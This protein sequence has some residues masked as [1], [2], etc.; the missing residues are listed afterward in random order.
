MGRKKKETPTQ[1]FIAG[2]EPVSIGEIDKAAD[3]YRAARDSRMSELEEE[4]EL[5]GKLLAVM[6][7]HNLSKYIYDGYE[8]V[9][10]DGDAKA[11]VKRVKEKAAVE[12]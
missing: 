8:V 9:V 4:I 10:L 1:K 11:K 12:A 6:R 7:K 3:N 5:Q 2:T